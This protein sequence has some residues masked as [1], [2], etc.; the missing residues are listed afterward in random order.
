MSR[1]LLIVLALPTVALADGGVELPSEATV[2][3]VELASPAPVD[4]IGA[5]TSGPALRL[6]IIPDSIEPLD[7]PL[8][9]ELLRPTYERR[10]STPAS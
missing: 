4:V 3:G 9:S 1:L 6:D 8:P 5:P 2:P 10:Y 7:A